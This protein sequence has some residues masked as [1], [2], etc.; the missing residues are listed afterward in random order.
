M[1]RVNSSGVESIL[2]M[3]VKEGPEGG[4]IAKTENTFEIVAREWF[5]KFTPTWDPDH[6]ED[7]YSSSGAGCFSLDGEVCQWERSNPPSS[8][9][10]LRRVESRGALEKRRTG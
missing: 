9:S 6:G 8:L 7:N 10:V 3:D 4:E 5:E 2:N 1:Q